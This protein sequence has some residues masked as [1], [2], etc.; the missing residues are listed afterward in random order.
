MLPIEVHPDDSLSYF[1]FHCPR[2]E[3]V[4]NFNWSTKTGLRDYSVHEV[5]NLDC[6]AGNSIVDKAKD[7]TII[8]G[9]PSKSL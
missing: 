7:V 4:F 2:I 9:K 3:I 1:P 5:H 6:G 8:N